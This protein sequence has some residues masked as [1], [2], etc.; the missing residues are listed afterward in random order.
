MP[1]VFVLLLIPTQDI[2]TYI[3][4]CYLF[5]YS[6][7][8]TSFEDQICTMRFK[9]Q[10]KKSSVHGFGLNFPSRK[11]FPGHLST[12]GQNYMITPECVGN[13]IFYYNYLHNALSYGYRN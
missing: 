13:S 2:F 11:M 10:R 7:M 5:S 9:F 6:I 8:L 4:P 3:E 1:R 12:G